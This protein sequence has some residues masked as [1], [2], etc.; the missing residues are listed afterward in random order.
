MINMNTV[1][2]QAINQEIT[3]LCFTTPIYLLLVKNIY[4]MYA[5]IIMIASGNNTCKAILNTF[6]AII[7]NIAKTTNVIIVF[8][9]LPII[10]SP[11]N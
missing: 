9:A 8:I 5:A 2:K 11:F 10:Y 7:N 6:N 1:E 4:T 3:S